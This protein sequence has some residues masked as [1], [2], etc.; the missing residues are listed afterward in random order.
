M[1]TLIKESILILGSYVNLNLNT[2]HHYRFNTMATKRKRNYLSLA[3]KLEIIKLSTN[4][5]SQTE[6]SRKFDCAPSTISKIIKKKDELMAAATDNP[7]GERKRRRVGKAETVESAL[8][9]WFKDAR[10]RDATITSAILEEKATQLA[11]KL[12]CIVNHVTIR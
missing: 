6:I 3:Q 5:V 8:L 9:T 4:K 7:N 11:N 2:S 12:D 1:S 10:S